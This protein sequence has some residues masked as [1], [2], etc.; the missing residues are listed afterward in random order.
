M[1]GLLIQAERIAQELLV[2]SGC[3][4][5]IALLRTTDEDDWKLIVRICEEHPDVA[6]T[7]SELEYMAPDAVVTAAD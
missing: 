2:P 7:L 3:I 5:S 1:I 6:Y 4:S